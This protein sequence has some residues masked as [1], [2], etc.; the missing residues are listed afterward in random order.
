MR[1]PLQKMTTLSQILFRATHTY[2]K[3]SKKKV[4]GESAKKSGRPTS[5]L[6]INF[7][8]NDSQEV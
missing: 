1:K 3:D 6:T 8:R 5:Y 2:P 7:S 4:T